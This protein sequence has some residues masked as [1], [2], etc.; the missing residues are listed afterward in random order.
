MKSIMTRIEALESVANRINVVEYVADYL[1]I[2]RNVAM[3]VQPDGCDTISTDIPEFSEYI[4]SRK[5]R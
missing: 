3:N 1:A 2:I 5:L 4:A